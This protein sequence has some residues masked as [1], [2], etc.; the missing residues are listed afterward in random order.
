MSIG[1]NDI[2]SKFEMNLVARAIVDHRNRSPDRSYHRLVAFILQI[3]II[4][5]NR[6]VTK[7]NGEIGGHWQVVPIPGLKAGGSL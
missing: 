3:L 7:L 6:G 1:C 4:E 5:T 2:C